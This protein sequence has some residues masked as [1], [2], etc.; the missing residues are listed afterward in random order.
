MTPSADDPD[1]IPVLVQCP[2]CG[3]MDRI[4]STSR[5]QMM[6][7][8][9]CQRSFEIEEFSADGGEYAGS[10]W[11]APDG[12][13]RAGAG[14]WPVWAV[15]LFPFFLAMAAIAILGPVIIPAF[16]AL[17][18][19]FQGFAALTFVLAVLYLVVSASRRKRGP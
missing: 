13:D 18:I 11:D 5:G 14:R 16:G 7:C 2:H 15:L 6:T 3:T 9:S 12:P 10:I 19:F 17:A 1:I 8:S 4:G